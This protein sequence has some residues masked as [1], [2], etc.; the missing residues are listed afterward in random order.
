MH[1]V[2]KPLSPVRVMVGLAW[3]GS[4]LYENRY[5]AAGRLVLDSTGHCK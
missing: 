5:N 4:F 2:C 3:L 1:T